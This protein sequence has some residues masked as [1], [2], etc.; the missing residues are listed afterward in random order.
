MCGVKPLGKIIE[1]HQQALANIERE[2]AE[3][4]RLSGGLNISNVPWG[5]VDATRFTNRALRGMR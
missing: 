2:R 4:A 5:N 3:K 1:E